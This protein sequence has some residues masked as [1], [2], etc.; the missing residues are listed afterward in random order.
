MNDPLPGLQYVGL[1]FT[2]LIIIYSLFSK[3][4]GHFIAEESNTFILH[5]LNFIQVVYLFKFTHLHSA[6]MYHF[7]NGFGFMHILFWPNFFYGT[8]PSGYAEY[9]AE[10]SLIPDANFFRNAGSS[11]SFLLVMIL[12]TII[13]VIVSYAVFKSKFMD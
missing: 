10:S 7:L 1:V 2:I 6:G 8:I 11:I 13:G 12:V 5:M 9:P 3:I 4:K